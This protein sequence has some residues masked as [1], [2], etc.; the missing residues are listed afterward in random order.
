[1]QVLFS[2]LCKLIDV[3]FTD[4]RSQAHGEIWMERDPNKNLASLLL[5]PWQQKGLLNPDLL[6][7][8]LSD[9]LEGTLRAETRL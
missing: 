7:S 1:M 9:S 2:L 6:P 5:D 4:I 3:E 8:L